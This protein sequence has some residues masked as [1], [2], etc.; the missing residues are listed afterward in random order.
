MLAVSFH[1]NGFISVL[2][3]KCHGY[4]D[5]LEAVA[6]RQTI[7]ALQQ[8]FVCYDRGK[9]NVVL[10]KVSTDLTPDGVGQSYKGLYSSPTCTH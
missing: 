4:A 5:S 6:M 2:A 3:L 10:M 8:S 1:E 7:V 9:N